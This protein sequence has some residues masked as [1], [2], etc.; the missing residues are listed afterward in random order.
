MKKGYQLNIFNLNDKI[1]QIQVKNEEI[2]SLLYEII[3][4]LSFFFITYLLS[5]ITIIIILYLFLKLI[6]FLFKV[7]EE[8]II[9]IKNM[10]F[11]IERKTLFQ[12]K[13]YFYNIKNLHNII[14]NEAFYICKVNYYLYFILNI[15]EN[16][17]LI[18]ENT[19]INIKDQ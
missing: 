13:K 7:K 19:S 9:L 11:Q 1:K 6:Y 12:T 5:N 2:S 14:I 3:L 17:I 18:F 8:N 16:M 4:F 15:Q 10:R